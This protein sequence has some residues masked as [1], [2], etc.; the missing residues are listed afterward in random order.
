MRELGCRVEF[1]YQVKQ[2]PVKMDTVLHIFD[3]EGGVKGEC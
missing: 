2:I 3:D 1:L